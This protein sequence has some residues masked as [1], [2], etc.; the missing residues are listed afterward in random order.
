M[1]PSNKKIG[2][3]G[4][5]QLGKMLIEAGQ[6]WNI[7]YT[8]LETSP[9]PAANAANRHIEGS[10]MDAGKIAEL[11]TACDILTY[12]IEHINIDVLLK[13]EAQGKKIIP[14]PRILEII[15]DKG[16]QKL[17]FQDHQIPSTYFELVENSA[18]WAEKLPKLKGGKV[19]AKLR[20]GGYD[21]KGVELVNKQEMLDDPGKIPFDGP[22]VLEEFV[23]NAVELSVI[24]A[25]NEAGDICTFPTVEMQFDPVANLVEF[26][27][28]PANISREVDEKAKLIAME[29]ILKMQGVGL[30]AVEMFMDQHQAIY[31]NE[32]APR[33]HNSGH[34]TIEACYTSQYEQLNRILLDLPLGDTSLIKPAAMINLLG[35]EGV[36]GA[37]EITGLDHILKIPGVY[38]HLYNK[39]ETK[40]KRKMG[41]ITIIGDT[42]DQVKENA[43][44]VKR[45]LGMRKMASA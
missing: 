4:G 1:L 27:F 28:S 30:F 16:L 24:V 23:E 40:P 15:Q 34:H 44:K 6:P 3:I 38:I 35:F 29:T 7:D 8:I 45:Y 37:Y 39:A 11:A 41:H 25:R 13:L 17:F 26:L 43:S 19:A 22:V 32:I 18:Q 33:P 14:S 21:G 20:K 12:E 5:G 10:L 9:A 42:L 31:V 2:I 36:Q